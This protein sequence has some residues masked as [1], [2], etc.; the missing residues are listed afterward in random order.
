MLFEKISQNLGRYRTCDES[1]SNVTEDQGTLHGD[2]SGLS[3]E[4]SM[5]IVI[6]HTYRGRPDGTANQYR[7]AST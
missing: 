1:Q 2:E 7:P 3:R 4:F 5:G 6:E